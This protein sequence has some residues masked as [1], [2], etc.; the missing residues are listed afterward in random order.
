[1]FQNSSN[2]F[3]MSSFLDLF[4]ICFSGFSSYE[5]TLEPLQLGRDFQIVQTELDSQNQKYPSGR[6]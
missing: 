1:M 4:G 2:F 5:R 3:R 6:K